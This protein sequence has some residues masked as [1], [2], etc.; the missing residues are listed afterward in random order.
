MAI[1]QVECLD[2]PAE[3]RPGELLKVSEQLAK[4]GV[5][6]DALWGYTDHENKPNI[7]A[8]GKDPGKLR[9]ALSK[10][11]VSAHASQCFCAT[12]EDKT[13]ALLNELRA[14]AD[15]NINITCLDALA[16][17]GRYAAVFWVSN[18][19]LAKAKQVLKVR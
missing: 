16:T 14:L 6:L 17:G 7:A 1:K 4:Q 5:N 15:A 9:A 8:I 19:D 12:G 3:N 13:G 18:A 11:G 10:V 2:W